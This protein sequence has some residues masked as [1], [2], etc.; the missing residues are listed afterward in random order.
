MNIFILLIIV[1]VLFTIA[2]YFKNLSEQKKSMSSVTNDTPGIGS[3][4]KLRDYF[5][6]H[7]E[8]P[9]FDELIRQA[10]G[11]YTI[12]SKVR[13]EDVVTTSK[14]LDYREKGLRRNYIKSKHLDFVILDAHGKILA[15]I[16]LDGKSHNTEK[17]GKYDKIKD[18][19]LN[20]VGCKLCRVKVGENY[21]F[22][23]GLIVKNLT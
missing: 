3:Y 17:Q 21:K 22:E 1:A 15:V 23:I 6:T 11:Q 19:I 4:Y 9:F 8:K 14:Q 12:L 7:T 13:L 18:D 16:E 5:F 10:Q 20:S 2:F